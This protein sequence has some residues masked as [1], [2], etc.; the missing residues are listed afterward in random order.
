MLDLYPSAFSC[1]LEFEST[2]WP[3]SVTLGKSR[4]AVRFRRV[5]SHFLHCNKNAD[6]VVILSLQKVETHPFHVF[7]S[8]QKKI[9][10]LRLPWEISIMVVPVLLIMTQ[11]VLCMFL[12]NV[13]TFLIH[14]GKQW[15]IHL[16]FNAGRPHGVF[17]APK[18]LRL[19]LRCFQT[20]Q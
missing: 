8:G 17:F 13:S 4:N 6:C 5:R 15:K 16:R 14:L 12:E 3:R 2:L 10:P 7:I 11:K 20:M 19:N 18:W 9:F 1:F